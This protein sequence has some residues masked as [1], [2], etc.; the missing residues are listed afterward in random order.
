MAAILLNIGP[1]DEII[2]PSYTFVSTALPFES[3]GAK[4]IFADSE[5]DRP[6]LDLNSALKYITKNT[7]AIIAVHYAGESVNM[8]QLKSIDSSIKIIE[9][10]AQGI[11]SKYLKK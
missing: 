5:N 1:G 6:H 3:R 11:F 4:I 10:N 9:D 8:E 7:K 2:I